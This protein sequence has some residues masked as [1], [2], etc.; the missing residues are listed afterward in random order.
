VRKPIDT[1]RKFPLAV[2]FPQHCVVRTEVALPMLWLGTVP[3]KTISDPVFSFRQNVRN[4]GTR[5]QMDYEYTSFVD[6]VTANRT[7]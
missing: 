2:P 1:V 4:C 7:G 6:S 5:L 3:D